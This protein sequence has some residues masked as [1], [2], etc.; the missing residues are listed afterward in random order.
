MAKGFSILVVNTFNKLFSIKFFP[1]ILGL[2]S[3]FSVF[4]FLYFFGAYGIQEGI[5]YSGH[6]HLFRSLSFGVLTF[7][8]LTA[9]EI[10]LK[11]KLDITSLRSSIMWYLSLVLLGSQLIFILFNFFWNWQEWNLEAYGF[12]MKEFPLM[13]VVP[14]SFY[15]VLKK[16]TAPKNPNLS[17]LSFQSEN[18]KEQLKIKLQNF[19]Y[20]NSSEN[21]ITISY[22]LN[23][24]SKHHL[25]RKPLKDLEQELK[26]YP[27]IERT[28]RSYLV[29]RLNIQAV[30]QLKGK[31]F[32][33]VKGTSVPVSKQYQ[34]QFLD[35]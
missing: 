33:E 5:S 13:M 27:E 18:G 3:G 22:T 24:Q 7:A 26:A 20:A 12:I 19:L 8:Y 21:Y 16:I 14:L 31:V 32:L 28:H 11:P 25:I 9:F 4:Y 23:G 6:S 30:K 10:W 29:N 1:I 17:Y 2:I 15:L 34:P 35:E